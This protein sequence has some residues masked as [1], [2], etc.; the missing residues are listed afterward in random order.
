MSVPFRETYAL[1]N[2]RVKK[3]FDMI[4]KR[5]KD[6]LI[7]NGLILFYIKNNKDEIELARVYSVTRRGMIT[8]IVNKEK[9]I[10][11]QYENILNIEDRIAVIEEIHKVL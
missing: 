9:Q 11:L 10:I 5:I 4:T 8:F 6:E 7:V 3:R 1:L 2:A